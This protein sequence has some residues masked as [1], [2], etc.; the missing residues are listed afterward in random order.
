MTWDWKF[1]KGSS[2]GL[3]AQNV[4]EVCPQVVHE[5]ED[6]VMSLAYGNLVGVLVEA[7]KALDE[8]IENLKGK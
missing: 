7:I 6:G 5:S 4:K 1:K 3:I 8:K 2:L